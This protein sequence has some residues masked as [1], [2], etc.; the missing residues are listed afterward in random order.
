MHREEFH[1]ADNGTLQITDKFPA[2]AGASV[3]PDP[4]E[5]EVG[6][7]QFTQHIEGHVVGDGSMSIVLSLA[8]GSRAQ[9]A[10][11]R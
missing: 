10:A 1:Q 4:K 8:I 7:I 3:R 6:A 5:N 11:C 2:L 9:W